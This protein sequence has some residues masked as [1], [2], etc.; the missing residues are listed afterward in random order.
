MQKLSWFKINAKE[1]DEL[2]G[3]IFNNQDDN[4]FKI[5]INKKNPMIWKT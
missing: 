1:F 4:D 5:K 3:D 2:T